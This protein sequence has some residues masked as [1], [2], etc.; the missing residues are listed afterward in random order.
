MH[1][2]IRWMN[3]ERISIITENLPRLVSVFFHVKKIFRH[4]VSSTIIYKNFTSLSKF[5][6]AWVTSIAIKYV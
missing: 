5:D 6:E 1:K 3:M 2:L 4:F